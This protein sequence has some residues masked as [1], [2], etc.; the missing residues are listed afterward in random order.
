MNQSQFVHELIEH[1]FG[2]EYEYL[3]DV[4]CSYELALKYIKDVFRKDD[5]TGLIHIHTPEESK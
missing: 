5:L 3:S 2:E 4:D 1:L